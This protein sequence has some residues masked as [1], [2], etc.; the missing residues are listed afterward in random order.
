[1]IILAGWFFGRTGGDGQ[2]AKYACQ[3][4]E[5]LRRHR[6]IGENENYRLVVT[7]QLVKLDPLCIDG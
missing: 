6:C 2:R 7:M 1:M 5:K 4:E 3:D